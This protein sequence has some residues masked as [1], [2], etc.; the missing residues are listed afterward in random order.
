MDAIQYFS[1]NVVG[2]QLETGEQRWYIIECYLT[3]D[4]TSTIESVIAALKECPQGSELLVAG[5]LNTNLD[6]PEGDWM[7]EDIAE[8]L[9]ASVLEDMSYHLLP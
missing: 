3:L 7:E 5:D 8:A 2:F 6:Q 9:T 1:T 4:D